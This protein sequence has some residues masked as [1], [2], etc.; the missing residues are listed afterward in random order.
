MMSDADI[1]EAAREQMSMA[2]DEQARRIKEAGLEGKLKAQEGYS[3]EALEEII[4][5]KKEEL[6]SNYISENAPGW[7][8]PFMFAGGLGAGL[9]DPVTMATSFLPVPGLGKEKMLMQLGKATAWAAKRGSSQALARAGV[10][11]AQGAAAGA[12]GSLLLEPLVYAGQT[13]IQADY[14]MYNSLLNVG[15]GAIFLGGY[16]EWS[17]TDWRGAAGAGTHAPAVGVCAKDRRKPC[18]DE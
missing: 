9:L 18:L 8:I 2:L 11:A 4:K 13:A 10:S 7:H 15:A 6:F 16:Q 12:F 1:L 17:G 14:S 3:E 5:A